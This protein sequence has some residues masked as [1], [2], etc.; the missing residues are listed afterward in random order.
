MIQKFLKIL[1]KLSQIVI[2]SNGDREQ[3]KDNSDREQTEDCIY[4]YKKSLFLEEG[5]DYKIL[6]WCNATYIGSEVWSGERERIH[7]F[8]RTDGFGIYVVRSNDL[9]KEVR[10][11]QP[12][13]DK[14]VARIRHLG[15]MLDDKWP[16]PGI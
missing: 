6:G 2:T 4:I 15:V 14:L 7:K 10:E 13:E 9:Y 12:D 16:D 3:A 5:K 11:W 8:K 1:S